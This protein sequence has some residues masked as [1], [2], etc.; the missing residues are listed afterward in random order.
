MVLV[1]PSILS[2]D[3]SCLGK[4][5]KALTTAGADLIHIDVMDGVFVPN[6]TFGAPV[7]KS[8]RKDTNLPFDVHLMVEK[9]S[10]LIKDFA[11][12]G[13][14]L[15]TVHLE[16]K[17]EIPYLISLVK[18]EK[19][20]VGISI[21]P[22]TKVAD[23]LPYIPDIDLILVMSVEPGFGGQN[24]QQQA[25]KKIAD[26]KELIGKKKVLISV[27]GGINDATAPACVY[28]GADILVAGSYVFKNKPYQKAINK[29]KG[30]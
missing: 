14:D 4:E 20:K 30:C 16:C 2:A 18:K 29:L 22:N 12:A 21:K 7:I 6:L 8:I 13:A 5:I 28:A 11:D 27:D 1:A 24:F 26:L 9:P 19:K 17:E 15:I 10:V 3:F 25:I 23:I